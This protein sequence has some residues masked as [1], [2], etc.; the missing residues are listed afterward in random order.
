MDNKNLEKIR[1]SLA[2]LMAMAILEKFPNAKLGIG[3]T[4]ENGFYYDFGGISISPED[5]PKLE[6]RIRELIKQN[7]KFKKEIITSTEAK[8]LFKNQPYKLE[9]IKEIQKTKKP[10]LIYKTFGNKSIIHNSQ[11]IIPFIDLCAGPHIKSTKEINPDAFKLT[12]IA[13]AYWQRSEKNQML[14]RIYGV[15]FETKKELEDYL[16]KMELA[17]KCDHRNIGEK[18]GLFMVDEQIGKGLPLWL[19][20]GYAIRKKLEDYIYEIEK[21]NGYLHVLT[22]QIAKEDLYKKSGHLAHYKDDMYAPITIDNEKYYLRPMNCPHHHSIYKHG[23]RSYRE[24]PLRIAEFGTV[25]RYER[26][27]VLSGLIR[28]RGFTQNDAHIYATEENLEKEIISI[29]DLHKKVFDDFGIK[30]YWYRL[31]LPNFKNPRTK[32]KFGAG[33]SKEKEIWKR[34]ENVLKKSLQNMGHKFVEAIGEA[35]FYGPKIDIQMKDLYGKEDTIATIQVDYYSAPK[36]N[37]SYIA[38]DGKEK[39]AIVIHRAIFGSFDR[40]FAFLIEKTCGALPLWLAPVQ[41]KILAISEKQNDYA[42][43]ILKELKD[44]GIDVELA[45]SD[46]TLGKRIREA[47][48]Q[49]IPYILIIGDKESQN[50]SVNIRHYKRGQEGEIKIE[51]LI[52]KIKREVLDKVI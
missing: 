10:I 17:E 34:G 12:K 13:G 7:L 44:N 2:H 43:K 11:F 4:I 1:H 37:L 24:L 35:T 29:L 27:G 9:L 5:L 48:M 50:N 52:E 16:K 36:F 30:D 46:E 45:P 32:T 8:K 31:S 51:K 26:S 38:Q 15:A 22:P 25:Y 39:P 18:L 3:P 33:H 21:E 6:K 47:E 42:E 49:K 19:P 41:V 28:V 14:T 20:K 23:K 40:F